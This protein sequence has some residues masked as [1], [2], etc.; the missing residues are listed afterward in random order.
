VSQSFHIPD[1]A[2][3]YYK[4]NQQFGNLKCLARPPGIAPYP[5]LQGGL[6]SLKNPWPEDA[7]AFVVF[8]GVTPGPYETWLVFALL[9][10][11][12]TSSLILPSQGGVLLQYRQLS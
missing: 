7:S 12:L 8:R 2:W 6:I 1:H 3:N 11:V 5:N 4:T 10:P 9:I